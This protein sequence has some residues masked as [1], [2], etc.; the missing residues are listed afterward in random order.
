MSTEDEEEESKCELKAD[1][2]VSEMHQQDLVKTDV[3]NNTSVE[4]YSSNIS[5]DTVQDKDRLKVKR[6]AKPKK[7]SKK[8]ELNLKKF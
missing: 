5:E 7:L 6:S 4:N 2:K 8:E 1:N 3:N